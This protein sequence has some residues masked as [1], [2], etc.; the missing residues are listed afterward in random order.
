[1][2]KT[3]VFSLPNPFFTLKDKVFSNEE[4]QQI[5]VILSGNQANSFSASD[6]VK[7][8]SI[9]LLL[10]GYYL[11]DLQKGSKTAKVGLFRKGIYWM[12]VTYFGQS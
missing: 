10:G 8:K 9:E 3:V 6:I 7:A 2:G 12:K 4:R 5:S 1:M 11:L